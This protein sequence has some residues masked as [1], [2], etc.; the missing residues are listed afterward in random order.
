[1]DDEAIT[2]GG[3]NHSHA[4]KD[5]YDSIESGEFPEWTLYIQTLDPA[6]EDNFNFDPLDATKVW[7]EEQFP[8]QPVGRMVLDKNV[9]NF[10]NE[11]EMLAFNPGVSIPGI[12]FSEDKL[13]QSRLFS[14][15]D[16]QRHRLGPNYLQLPINA[17]KCPFHNNHYDGLMNMVE[18]KEEIDYFPS[19]HTSVHE[20]KRFP[21]TA[22][23]ISGKREKKMIGKENNFEQVCKHP[24]Q[25]SSNLQNWSVNIN[26]V[27]RG[28]V[29]IVYF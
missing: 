11:N 29:L 19:R 25:L 10:F 27:V 28:V 9:D 21:I 24:G 2:V 22:K 7:P 3:M 6:D 26:C 8:M 17:P 14:Y 23:Q 12:D 15:G 18:R 16:T 4:T 13:L 20:A 1:M 5:L